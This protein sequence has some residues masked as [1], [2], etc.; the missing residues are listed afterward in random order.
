MLQKLLKRAQTT[1][2]AFC[3]G[4]PPDRIST[5]RRNP[6]ELEVLGGRK[7]V[8]TSKSSSNSPASNPASSSPAHR[9]SLPADTHGDTLM[10]SV[11]YQHE[12]IPSM[13]NYYSTIGRDFDM[14]PSSFIAP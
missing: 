2:A 11:P 3:A 9:L 1:F 6:D 4:S 7:S 12:R 10:P 13:S 5:S 14:T 8:I